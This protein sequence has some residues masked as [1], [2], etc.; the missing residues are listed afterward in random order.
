MP[1]ILQRESLTSEG[2][3]AS[4]SGWRRAMMFREHG[5][6]DIATPTG[7]M[8]LHVFQPAAPGRYPSVIVVRSAGA[9]P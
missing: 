8:R 2:D 3:E 9:T 1:D 6:A 7:P 4:P 5:T